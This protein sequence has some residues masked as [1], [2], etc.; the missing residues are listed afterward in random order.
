MEYTDEEIMKL[1]KEAG[2]DDSIQYHI[3]KCRKFPGAG[4]QGR[5]N[6]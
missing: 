3:K 1:A 5:R 2:F 4:Y 6:R